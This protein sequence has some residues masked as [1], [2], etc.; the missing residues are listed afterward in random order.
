MWLKINICK[1]KTIKDVLITNGNGYN[2]YDNCCLVAKDSTMFY[3]IIWKLII[4]GKTQ[5]ES[6]FHMLLVDNHS[7]NN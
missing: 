3:F 7:S 4:L 5:M 2:D 6:I 1:R